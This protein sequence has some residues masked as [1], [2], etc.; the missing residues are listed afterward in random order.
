MGVVQIAKT[1]D[2]TM[3]SY[4]NTKKK[5]FG[6]Q[7]A[8]CSKRHALSSKKS[9][10]DYRISLKKVNFFS[11][12]M[13]FLLP[14]IFYKKLISPLLPMSCRFYPTCSEY[15]FEAIKRHGFLKGGSLAVWRLL[16]CNPFCKGGIDLVP[17]K[18]KEK[19]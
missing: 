11:L 18:V 16:R 9:K 13:L 6:Q 2:K 12:S 17:E 7:T 8:C 1:R 4:T 10:E 14:L 19:R 3:S 5:D 15:A